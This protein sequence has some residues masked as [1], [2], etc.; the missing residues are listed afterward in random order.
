MQKYQADV[1]AESSSFQANAKIAGKN[2]DQAGVRLQISQAYASQSQQDFQ[3][4]ST[5]YSWAIN[6]LTASTGA[7]SAPPP[8]QA[9]QRAEEQRSTA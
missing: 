8:Q 2:L 4:S 7:S 6:E 3:K 5:L 1:N 9:A